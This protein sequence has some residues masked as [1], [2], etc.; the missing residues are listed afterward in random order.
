MALRWVDRKLLSENV[1][2][3][4]LL[5]GRSFLWF[6]WREALRWPVLV[7]LSRGLKG[8]L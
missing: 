5:L 2:E 4:E 1:G 8:A 3:R 6:F 7:E